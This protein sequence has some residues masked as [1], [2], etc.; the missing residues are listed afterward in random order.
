MK[1]SRVSKEEY[2]KEFE[3]VEYVYDSV[4]FNELNKT[5]L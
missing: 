2:L 3:D 5:V 4:H 1:V